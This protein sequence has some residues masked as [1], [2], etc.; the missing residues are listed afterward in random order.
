MMKF[1]NGEIYFDLENSPY[2]S[3]SIEFFNQKVVLLLY[4][5]SKH[6]NAFRK[7]AGKGDEVSPFVEHLRHAFP[8]TNLKVVLFNVIS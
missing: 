7:L 3:S 8:F 1:V 4:T 6:V 5:S 2:F